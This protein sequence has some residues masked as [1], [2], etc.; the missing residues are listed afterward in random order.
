MCASKMTEEAS[1]IH[2]C[3]KIEELRAKTQRDHQVDTEAY[4][5]NRKKNN[6]VHLKCI[7]DVPGRHKDTESEGNEQFERISK[8]DS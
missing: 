2:F 1:E 4:Y 7:Q 3:Y 5:G 8:L 6:F